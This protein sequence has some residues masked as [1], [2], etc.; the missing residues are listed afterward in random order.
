VPK[1]FQI[2]WDETHPFAG[3]GLRDVEV[4]KHGESVTLTERALA[5]S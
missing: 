1:K 5:A 4:A 2:P 3:L